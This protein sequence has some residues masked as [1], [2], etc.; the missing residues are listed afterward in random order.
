MK[1]TH[2]I[3]TRNFAGSER[4]AIE[5]AN[6]QSKTHDVS[7]VISANA[8]E[9]RPEALL[10][11]IK[12][13][14]E[15]F[16]VKS[17][18]PILQVFEVRRLLKKINP[19]IAHGHLS[20]ACRALS[21]YSGTSKRVATL[22][23]HYKKQQ[24]EKLDGLIAIAPWQLADI[25]EKLLR[26]TIQI[27]NWT[28]DKTAEIGKRESIRNQFGI[29]PTEILIGA[30]GRTV[31]SKGFDTLIKA[32]RQSNIPNA[33]LA[34][35]GSGKDWE[36]SKALAEPDI[37][38]PGFSSAPEDWLAAFDAF[39]SSAKSEPFGLVF[40]EAMNS[41]LPILS[42]ASQGA[43]HLHHLIKSPLIPI[44]NVKE[45]SEALKSFCAHP[46]ARIHY[47]LC[48]YR[49]E[50]KLAEIETFYKTLNT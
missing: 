18:L 22:H 43:I 4:Y 30:L 12:P 27:D 28:A 9:S 16:V 45:M 17:K 33:R 25:P 40:L 31:D 29:K 5:L 14:V 38:M 2:L 49:I 11:R 24:H 35:I 47:D 26:H 42:T 32:F 10:H 7:I 19:D 20:T 36:K 37:I 39:V 6:S 21:G 41:N 1:I 50:S 13:S 46:I 8:A 48:Q 34:I 15:V 3:L 44:N 23:I